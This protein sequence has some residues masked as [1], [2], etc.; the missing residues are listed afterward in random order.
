MLNVINEFIENYFKLKLNI[1][2]NIH[3]NNTV[4]IYSF[5]LKVEVENQNLRLIMYLPS[6]IIHFHSLLE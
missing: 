6:L 3:K 1:D 2:W 4:L 5:I